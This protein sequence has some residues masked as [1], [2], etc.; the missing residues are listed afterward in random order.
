MAGQG[1]PI[2]A[3]ASGINLSNSTLAQT[4]Q[5][6][7]GTGLGPIPNITGLTVGSQTGASGQYLTNNTITSGP[8]WQGVTTFN[9]DAVHFNNKKI[10]FEELHTMMDTVKKRLLILTPNFEKHEKYQMLKDAYDEYRAIEALLS[11][12]KDLK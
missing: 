1:A 7:L 2:P 12:P 6:M 9:A 11:D 4:G 5:T 3:S 8:S 10:D